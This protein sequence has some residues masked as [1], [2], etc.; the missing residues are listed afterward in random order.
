M[1]ADILN[2]NSPAWMLD[3]SRNCA[4]NP[5]D[6]TALEVRAISDQWHP[7]PSDEHRATRLCDGCPTRTEC[8]NWALDFIDPLTGQRVTGIWGGTTTT[9]RHKLRGQAVA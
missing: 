8:L 7:A 4:I 3:P 5:D 9:Q 6:F 2:V 1:T